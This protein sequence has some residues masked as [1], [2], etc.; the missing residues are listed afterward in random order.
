MNTK[1][2]LAL[3]G[4]ATMAVAVGLSI[5]NRRDRVSRYIRTHSRWPYRCAKV[6]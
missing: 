1:I 4:I 3:A 2:V 6:M 5:S